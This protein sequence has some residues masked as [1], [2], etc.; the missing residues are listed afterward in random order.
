VDLDQLVIE[1]KTGLGFS[2]EENPP[3]DRLLKQKIKTV[4]SFMKRAG[5]SDAAMNDDLAV[6]VIVMGVSDIWEQA[7]GAVKL[8]PAYHT[9]LTQL[10]CGGDS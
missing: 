6:G 10:A 2:I 7:G 4:Q 9:L 3:I 8:S 5:V 1:C